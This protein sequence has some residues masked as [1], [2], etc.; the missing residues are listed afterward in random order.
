MIKKLLLGATLLFAIVSFSSVAQA[1][2]E[3]IM[4]HVKK[5]EVS[6]S[7][8]SREQFQK[9]DQIASE[10][11]QGVK[12]SQTR[13]FFPGTSYVDDGLYQVRFKDAPFYLDVMGGQSVNGNGLHMW[14]HHYG[15]AA[16]FYIKNIGNGE[17]VLFETTGWKSVE[18]GG[19]NVFNGAPVQIWDYQSIGIPTQRWRLE[20]V[21]DSW[22]IPD[23]SVKL[24]NINSGKV[25]N[26]VD[27]KV[28]PYVRV[29]SWESLNISG[30]KFNLERLMP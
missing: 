5:V 10:K 27:G 8:I 2:S 6:N 19:S 13:S 24:V 3:S 15:A 9:A 26:A 1:T 29:N 4:E 20:P 25:L 23:G 28:I 22:G 21:I 11:V 16:V 12:P 7:I 30:Q 17:F 14:T 18:I